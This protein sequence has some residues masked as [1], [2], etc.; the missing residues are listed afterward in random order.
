MS[1]T[2]ANHAPPRTTRSVARTADGRE[3]ILD[4]TSH[5]GQVYTDLGVRPHYPAAPAPMGPFVDDITAGVTVQRLR[6]EAG[7]PVPTAA[8][9]R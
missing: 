8:V 4:A 3:L 9:A 7:T 2:I 6:A 5:D 1:V